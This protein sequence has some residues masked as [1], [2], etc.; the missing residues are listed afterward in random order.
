M[1]QLHSQLLQRG[2]ALHRGGAI[3]EAEAAYSEVL[4]DAPDNADALY[5]LAMIRCHGGRLEEGIGLLQR[6]IAIAPQRA[7][8]H[9]LLGMA[10]HR[11][12]RRAEALSSLDRAIALEPSLA[13]AHG[14]R[15]TI[16]DELGRH[17]EA[18]GSFDRAL[19]LNPASHQDWCNRGAA[20]SELKRYEQ[21]IESCDRALALKPDFAGAHF[22]RAK[23]LI[24]LIRHEE[25]LAAFDRALAI[26]PD[27]ADA[28]SDRGLALKKVDRLE[29][30]LINLDRAVALKPDSAG[31]IANR[32]ITL[33]ELGQ[34]DAADT[35]FK[36]AIAIDPHLPQAHIGL[37]LSQ[38]QRGNWEEG[39]QNYEYRDQGDEPAYLPLPF[40]RWTGE[41]LTEERLM[42]MAEQGLGDA[43]QFCR[44]GP[45]LAARGL[46]VTI[47][48]RDR[49]AR[50]FSRIPDVRIA[51]SIYE[52]ERDR[53]IP[54][55]S[56]P[57]IFSITPETIPGDA[58]YLSAE[59]R[60]VE[61]WARRMGG[62]GFK[63]GIVWHCEVKPWE[64]MQNRAIP[65]QLFAPLAAIPGV[66]LIALQKGAGSEQIAEVPFRDRIETLGKDFDAG[67]DA[68]ID[69]AAVM[70]SLDLIVSC[71]TSS[72]HLAGAL[73][74]PVFTALPLIP[75]WRWL[76]DREDTPWYPT[77]R[78]FRQ[79]KRGEW[80]DVIE[81]IVRAVRE[82]VKKI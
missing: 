73:A 28:L 1:N 49:L 62:H 79:T 66:R 8:A 23:A 19:V 43:I 37:S 69:T 32:G 15:G 26:N 13:D 61:S 70:M 41:P 63:I 6:A 3:V 57:G 64:Y 11:L 44:F 53:R 74:R 18:I 21:A 58:P 82:R 55:M 59:P 36:R 65:L 34:H 10:L 29:E 78:L 75:D 50:L 25:A 27:F 77:M 54:M 38:L 20:L 2:L 17:A 16:L 76:L 81:R 4:R 60:L 14:N 9:N 5:Y 45:R 67:G 39:F 48:T 33:R 35:D 42:L 22:N 31:I 47:L 56:V 40:P 71:D 72:A 68:F 7:S 46:D 12:G 52:I 80:F 24:K 30:A 51:T